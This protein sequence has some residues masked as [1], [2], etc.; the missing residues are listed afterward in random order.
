[1]QEGHASHRNLA[2]ESDKKHTTIASV[3]AMNGDTIQPESSSVPQGWNEFC[4]LH[5]ISTAR[6]LAKQYWLF[7]N[8]NP[9]HDILAAEIFSLHFTDLFQQYF[10]NEVRESWG[11]D[12]YRFFP[13]SRVKDY[14][15]TGRRPSDDPSSTVAAK[16]EVE[17]TAQHEHID[18]TVSDTS[19]Q[20]A[21]KTWSSEELRPCSSTPAARPFI[22]FSLAQFRRSIRNIF[23]RKSADSTPPETREAET[24]ST[25]PPSWQGLQK[26]IL[27]WT[28][29]REPTIDVR[30]E[31]QLNY[32]MVDEKCMDGG[33]SWQRCRLV[34]RKSGTLE[35]DEYLL[36]LFDPPK[37]PRTKLKVSCCSIQEIRRCSRLE[38]PDNAN[39]FVLKANAT[40]VIFE[41]GDDQQL[42]SWIS[43]I[44]E[45]LNCWSDETE[46]ETQLPSNSDTANQSPSSG[47]TDS[48]TQGASVFVPPEQ[49]C[50]KTDHFLASSPWFHG[51][52]SRVKA[53]QLVQSQ[54]VEGHGVFLVR[55]SETRRGE[56]VLTFNFQ[57]RAKHL[58]LTLT[59]R[60]QCHVQH[61][62]FRS[63]LEM[64]QYFRLQPIP[65]ECGA[66]CDVKL[67]G[68]VVAG[69]Q[70]H[71]LGTSVCTSLLFP[72]AIQ[73]S[74]SE[75]SVS[76]FP[77]PSP[78]RHQYT[79]DFH[80]FSFP[81]QIFHRVPPPEELNRSFLRSEASGAQSSAHRESDYELDSPSRSRM[82]A[83]DN[84]YTPL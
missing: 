38:M 73:H 15:E 19:V 48:I 16:L 3:T 69:V 60:G 31:G 45:C 71:E 47:S 17:L 76:Q 46:G 36:E 12:Q 9:Q 5:A 78:L 53:A 26:R 70:P 56:Y 54:G 28:I 2:M 61:L 42:N 34:L 67:S 41:A 21:P 74:S 39:T 35:S 62:R 11:M 27:P 22:R 80:H 50:H 6:E 37:C 79:E 40:E 57:G 7:A 32:S 10:R 82:R 65:L 84:P 1:M 68:Y 29:T 64:L 4:K 44:K 58:R 59:E 52:I 24:D 75:R 63:V 14:R 66:A 33:T 72:L 13:F 8:Q 83:I 77:S 55:Q 81:E 51:P 25:E 18:Q 23:R 43:E 20:L 30:K 49:C